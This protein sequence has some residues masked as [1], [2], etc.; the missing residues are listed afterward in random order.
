M[1]GV[2]NRKSKKDDIELRSRISDSLVGRYHGK[3]NPNYKGENRNPK[4]V[5]RGIFKTTSKRKI[6]ESNFT[7]SICKKH[8]ESGLETHHITPFSNIFNEFMKS[9]YDGNQETLY[10]QITNYPDFMDE[11]NVIVVCHDCHKKL[12]YSDNHEPRQ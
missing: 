9:S 4:S 11:M 10:E 5:A 8:F 2:T 3:N 12:H 7:C 1:Q 6:R